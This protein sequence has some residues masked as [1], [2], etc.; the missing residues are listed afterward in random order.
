MY[1]CVCLVDMAPLLSLHTV[2][3]R[4]SV[5]Q[6]VNKSNRENRVNH[7]YHK[8]TKNHNCFLL[9]FQFF[10][11]IHRHLALVQLPHSTRKLF[12]LRMRPSITR[13]HMDLYF[14]SCAVSHSGGVTRFTACTCYMSV[15]K[16][17]AGLFWHAHCRGGSS[18]RP[19]LRC[20]TCG[21]SCVPAGEAPFCATLQ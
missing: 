12:Q 13:K 17:A 20:H 16:L 15:K 3:F 19:H 2:I 1:V 5:S 8:V 9:F 4:A 10:L 7:G 6:Q 21:A 11:S 18:V 14:Y